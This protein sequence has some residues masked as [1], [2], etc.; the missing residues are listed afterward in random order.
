MAGCR[1][2]FCDLRC[3]I[4]RSRMTR[5]LPWGAASRPPT[6]PTPALSNA[7]A[8]KNPWQWIL[9]QCSPL[10]AGPLFLPSNNN[11]CQ[12]PPPLPPPKI[13]INIDSK[14]CLLLRP[15]S[16]TYL[17]WLTVIVKDSND[18]HSAVAAADA[19]MESGMSGQEDRNSACVAYQ[20]PTLVWSCIG[21]VG[22][23]EGG[24]G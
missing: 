7:S 23:G 1:I 6:P 16:D 19:R 3:S 15:L 22:E 12:I 2:D 11:P 10:A 13:P 17:P 4:L 20:S 24:G 14:S 8:A 9:V 21:N 18:A 5:V